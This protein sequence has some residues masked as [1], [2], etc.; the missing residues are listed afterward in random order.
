MKNEHEQWIGAQ[1]MIP[2]LPEVS[3]VTLTGLRLHPAFSTITTEELATIREQELTLH[4]LNRVPLHNVKL[5]MYLHEPVLMG[6]KSTHNAGTVIR[7]IPAETP[8]TVTSAG[9]GA[10]IDPP[11]NLAQNLILEIQVLSPAESV[12]IPFYTCDPQYQAETDQ[13]V[14]CEIDLDSIYTGFRTPFFLE[15]TYQFLLRGEYVTTEIFV[16]LRYSYKNRTIASFPSQ[17]SR[18]PWEV[19]P[20]ILFRGVQLQG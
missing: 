15:G 13:P 6:G 9:A 8:W 2:K 18:E 11:Q 12:I 14:D 1:G 3:L 7:V 16:P 20:T 4:N 17:I 5:T 19:T 10:V